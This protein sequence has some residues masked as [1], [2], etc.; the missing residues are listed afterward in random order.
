MSSEQVAAVLRQSSMHGQL[1]KF[2]VARPVH[3]TVKDIEL[4]GN[5]SAADLANNLNEPPPVLN[6]NS[7]CINVRTNQIMDKR[8]DL[9]KIIDTEIEQIRLAKEPSTTA[10]TNEATTTEIQEVKQNVE[11]STKMEVDVIND[12]ISNNANNNSNDNNNKINDISTNDNN[13]KSNNKPDDETNIPTQTSFKNKLKTIPPPLTLPLSLPPSDETAI[14]LSPTKPKQQKL[15]ETSNQTNNQTN[16]DNNANDLIYSI[17]LNRRTLNEE[18]LIIKNEDNINN[19]SLNQILLKLKNLFSIIFEIEKLNDSNLIESTKNMINDNTSSN[20]ELNLTLY[21]NEKYNDLAQQPTN[22]E[23]YDQLIEINSIPVTNLI[24]DSTLLDLDR[25]DKINLKL[26]KN[27][28][29]KSY[30]LKQKWLDMLNKEINENNELIRMRKYY[31]MEIIVGQIDKTKSKSLGISLEGTVDIDDNGVE[32]YP[33]HYIRSIMKDGP[34]DKAE[35]EKFKT[36]DELLEIDFF[37]LY[38]INYLELLDIL[39][40]LKNKLIIMVCVRKTK[41]SAHSVLTDTSNS[42]NAKSPVESAKDET[43]TTNS[44]RSSRKDEN[45]NKN[46]NKKAKRAKSEGFLLGQHSPSESNIEDNL[47]SNDHPLEKTTSTSALNKNNNSNN[48]TST[49]NQ[50]EQIQS[51]PTAKSTPV[52]STE[53]TKPEEIEIVD[54]NNKNKTKYTKSLYKTTSTKLIKTPQ[55]CVRSRS[56]ELDGLSLWNKKVEHISIVKGEKGLGFSLIDYQQDPH[57]PLAKTM[58]VIRALVPNGVAQQD[59]RLMPGQRLV[60]INDVKLDEDYLIENGSSHRLNTATSTASLHRP[61]IDVLK[62]TVDLLKSI[63][64]GCI[65]RLGVQNPLPY[66]DANMNDSQHYHNGHTSTH[67]NQNKK[68][69]AKSSYELRDIKKKHK[70]KNKNIAKLDE[71]NDITSDDNNNNNKN[72]D[73]K[74]KNTKLN[75]SSN[76]SIESE[77]DDISSDSSSLPKMGS[78]KYGVVATSAPA[79]LNEF[80]R[81]DETLLHKKQND[82]KNDNN[83]QDNSDGE[84][85]DSDGKHKFYSSTSLLKLNTL[86]LYNQIYSANSEIHDQQQNEQQ[87]QQPT[88]KMKSGENLN[89]IEN[90]KSTKIVIKQKPIV[91]QQQQQDESSNNNVVKMK[92]SCMKSPAK[93]PVQPTSI[94]KSLSMPLQKKENTKQNLD[95]DYIE[96]MEENEDYNDSILLP[97]HKSLTNDQI[98][99][100]MTNST[101][102]F[103]YLL[104]NNNNNNKNNITSSNRNNDN[105][106]IS[107][108]NYQI[109]LDDNYYVDDYKYVS[110]HE[111]NK[112]LITEEQFNQAFIKN[113]NIFIFYF[114]ITKICLPYKMFKLISS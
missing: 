83:H 93:P 50:P 48:E 46:G 88:S 4:V 105:Q 63:N 99:K 81:I 3:N 84:E 14:S 24:N 112:M 71:F 13:D 65:V 45:S 44:T 82:D 52:I 27:F 64:V 80:C 61:I 41:K 2:I 32:T 11:E 59:G 53:S 33:H 102:Y 5:D 98:V 90:L 75:K 68:Q 62:F 89:I 17:E 73:N 111:H 8:V 106:L 86:G 70:I 58:I 60:S 110:S 104:G 72:S 19:N 103:N 78:L 55:L 6:E 108:S 76:S 36:G 95:Y 22:L 66:P 34:V 96:D 21:L 7:Q 18:A 54:E 49:S 57:N 15:E 10:T 109:V 91:K 25:L 29:F 69:N 77:N 40:T 51:I 37:R 35:Y 101:L 26:I 97:I 94:N 113:V 39:K 20:N 92:K 28:Q 30:K 31:D 38:A 23:L 47:M 79:I 114:I 74:S 16:N 100:R 107:D 1:V 56:L 67:L 42:Q 9:Q 43:T 12:N 87:H 85:S